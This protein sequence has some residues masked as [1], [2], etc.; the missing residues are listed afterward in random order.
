MPFE[1]YDV[2][3]QE[4]VSIADKYGITS[5]PAFVFIGKDGSVAN[6]LVGVV[7]PDTLKEQI[8]AISK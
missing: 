5:I 4:S 8:D 1:L 2:D 6:K 7:T 3:N